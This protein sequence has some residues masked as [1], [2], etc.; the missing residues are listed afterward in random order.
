MVASARRVY[1]A[2]PPVLKKTATNGIFCTRSV[3]RERTSLMLTI[4]L[5]F[6]DC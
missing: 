6:V 4:L 1:D 5:D 2:I 3:F